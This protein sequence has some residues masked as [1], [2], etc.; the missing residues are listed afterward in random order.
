ML[1]FNRRNIVF[2]IVLLFSCRQPNHVTVS[3][4]ALPNIKDEDTATLPPPLLP[5]GVSAAAF[6]VYNDSTISSFDVLND[7]SVA[8]WNTIIGGGDAQKPSEKTK[9]IF[10]GKLH[11]LRARIYNGKKKVVDQIIPGE[12]EFIIDHTGCNEVRVVITKG[13]TVV[14]QNSIPFHCGE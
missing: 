5:A 6:L 13:T 10:Y 4:V 3:N 2:I 12:H 1:Q 14:Y 9:I 8:L 11:G 7:K